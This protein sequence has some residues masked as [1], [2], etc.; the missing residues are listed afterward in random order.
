MKTPLCAILVALIA[1][2][3]AAATLVMFQWTPERILFAV[4]SLATRVHDNGA[5]DT[6][7]ECKIH[8]QG[9]FFFTIVGINDD[10]AAHVDMVALANRA[11]VGARDL[12]SAVRAFELAA[13]EPVRRLWS[14][15]VQH[16][17][18]TARLA[19]ATDGT[20]TL[21]VVFVSRREQ[22][23]AVKEYT[24]SVTGA[25]AETPARFYGAARNMRQDRGYIAVGIYADAQVSGGRLNGLEGAAFVN[26]FFEVQM[27]HELERQRQHGAPRIG[28]PVCMLQVMSGVASWVNGQQGACASIRP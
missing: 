1:G 27:A 3:P 22:A 24:G 18:A 7:T 19:I 4:D 6:V 14:D 25:V 11:A 9:N 12:N 10:P 20:M 15:V 16:R 26:A 2:Q 23:I 8:Q 5:I 13:A 21:S 17:G 28:L